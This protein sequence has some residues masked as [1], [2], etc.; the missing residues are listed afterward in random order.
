MQLFRPNSPVTKPQI[1]ASLV[2]NMI[3]RQI[4]FPQNK[5]FNINRTSC[6]LN[7]A[8]PSSFKIRSPALIPESAAGDP[9]ETYQANC[10]DKQIVRIFLIKN[11][12]L[13][14]MPVFNPKRVAHFL[15]H[16]C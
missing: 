5:L 13:I 15:Q 14:T 7:K 16:C 2:C 12:K 1:S 9:S 8:T 3:L 6:A 11:I 4:E 10:R